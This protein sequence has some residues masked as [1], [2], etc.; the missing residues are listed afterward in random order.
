MLL[1]DEEESGVS[2]RYSLRLKNE[3]LKGKVAKGNFCVSSQGLPFGFWL[4]KKIT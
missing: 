3:D 1:Q 2:Q 4:L